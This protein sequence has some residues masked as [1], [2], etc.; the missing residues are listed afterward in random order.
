MK[1]LDLLIKIYSNTIG[2]TS[3]PYSIKKFDLEDYFNIEK[4]LKKMNVPF[5]VGIVTTYGQGSNLGIVLSNKISKTKIKRKSNATHAF[6][7][8]RCEKGY[9]HRVV[10]QIGHGLS[11]NTLLS[12]IG[13]RDEVVIRIPN[14]L[15]IDDLVSKKVLEYLEMMIEQDKISNI[16]YDNTHTTKNNNLSSDCSGLIY[17]ALDYAF[18]ELGR[19]NPIK[20]E[21]RCGKESWTPVDIEFDPCFITI[22]NKGLFTN[23]N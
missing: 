4:E 10:E 3:W 13:H 19:Y 18:I 22:Y 5:C 23:I 21:K 8:I 15:I 6:A 7:Y 1:L 20:I 12:A 17:Q 14:P 2:K 11:V 16:P 9:K